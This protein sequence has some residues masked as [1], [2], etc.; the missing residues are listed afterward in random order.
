MLWSERGSREELENLLSACD[1][2]LSL[3]RSEGL[4][5]LPI[6]CMYLGKPVVA[7]DYG[8]VTDYLDETT[9]FPVP[10]ELR[11]LGTSYG[12]YPEGA[13]WA[14]PSIR[15]AVEQMRRVIE[16]PAVA[17]VRAEAARRRIVDMYSVEAA[18]LRLGVELQRFSLGSGPAPVEA[19]REPIL[20]HEP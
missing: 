3:H 12:P 6:E 5:L 13:A 9:G 17:A 4:G 14:E 10:Y 16:E 11:R 20:A 19:P 18:A 2:C 7:T 15:H 8:G 1:A